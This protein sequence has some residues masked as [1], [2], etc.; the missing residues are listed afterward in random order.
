MTKTYLLISIIVS[1]F[2]IG[3]TNTY[4]V[5]DI[6][7]K[8][9]LNKINLHDTKNLYPQEPWAK[10][11]RPLLGIA[12]SGGGSKIAP[13]AMGVLK[14][15][16]DEEWIDNVDIIS[17]VSG[18]GYSAYYFYSKALYEY[19]EKNDTNLTKFFQNCELDKLYHKKTYQEFS[20]S[21]NTNSCKNYGLYQNHVKKYQDL[22]SFFVSESARGA[23]KIDNIKVTG[24][25][26]GGLGASI[27]TAPIHHTANTLFDWKVELSPSQYLYKN[28]IVRAFGQ[29]PQELN[30]THNTESFQDLKE[31]TES[32]K[33]PLWIINAANFESFWWQHSLKKGEANLSQSI[34]EISPYGFGSGRYGYS[35]DSPDYLGLNLSR[36]TLASAAFAD[37]LKNMNGQGLIFAGAHLLNLRWGIKIPN[38]TIPKREQKLHNILPLPFYYLNPNASK[39]TLADGGQS[40]DN[41]GLYS[42]IKRGTKNIVIVSGSNDSKK[43]KLLLE[44]MC[45]VSKH[46]KKLGM[47]VSFQ[48]YPTNI[49][50]LETLDFYKEFCNK[51]DD[52]LISYYEWEKPIWKGII[53]DNHDNNISK[54]FFIKAAFDKNDLTQ[55]ANIFNKNSCNKD[56]CPSNLQCTDE[57]IC[58]KTNKYSRHYPSSLLYFWIDNDRGKE[59]ANF[60][61]TSTVTN[62]LNSSQ[63]LYQAYMDLGFYLSG[64]LKDEKFFQELSE[65][66]E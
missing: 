46:L 10:K 7:T 65:K 2:L 63:N 17:S 4:Y 64:Y 19:K 28:G 39:I 1:I 36:A 51:K 52:E 21:K 9:L 5:K 58:A 20:T 55:H 42:L 18:G 31:L 34:F 41:L 62:T 3:C 12:L 48:G 11:N 16:V 27:A 38:Y 37:A 8:P 49:N 13:F 32:K 33:V 35:I 6:Q 59:S 26:L 57:N 60:P 24:T 15:F 40:G 22:L 29:M 61:Q 30:L 14:R 66:K 56:N 45:A 54:L 47:N 44:D 50:D 25:L 43:D 23:T 53:K